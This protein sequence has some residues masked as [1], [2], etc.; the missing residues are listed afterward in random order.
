MGSTTGHRWREDY[1]RGGWVELAHQLA[2]AALV[3]HRVGV[4]TLA[5]EFLEHLLRRLDLVRVLGVPHQT[6]VTHAAH[7]SKLAHLRPPSEHRVLVDAMFQQDRK[8]VV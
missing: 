3:L 7:H 6:R 2:L 8:S 4:V 5:A 1:L